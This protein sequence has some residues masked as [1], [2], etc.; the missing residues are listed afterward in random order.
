[1][2]RSDYWTLWICYSHQGNDYFKEKKT[3]KNPIVDE[4]QLKKIWTVNWMWASS[5]WSSAVASVW[6]GFFT[7]SC[8]RISGSR[9]MTKRSNNNDKK[10]V[11]SFRIL[12]FAITHTRTHRDLI[13]PMWI[14]RVAYSTERCF[15]NCH[16]ISMWDQMYS[17]RN[18]LGLWLNYE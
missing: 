11:H 5:K 17:W 16:R 15:C 6:C 4:F 3:S 9:C 8:H 12:A 14:R 2:C 10:L 7:S 1:M 13:H 18:F